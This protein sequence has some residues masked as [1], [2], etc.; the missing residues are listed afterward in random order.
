MIR[1]AE[2]VGFQT[3]FLAE[4]RLINDNQWVNLFLGNHCG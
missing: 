4:I 1:I 3:G 2:K